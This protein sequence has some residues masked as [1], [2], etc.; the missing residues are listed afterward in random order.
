[1]DVAARKARLLDP[2]YLTLWNLLWITLCISLGR[3]VDNPCVVWIIP[4]EDSSTPCP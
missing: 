2:R 4:G 1:M 3:L